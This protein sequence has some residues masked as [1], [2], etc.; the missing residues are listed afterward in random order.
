ML[1]VAQ[2]AQRKQILRNF[3]TTETRRH[4]EITDLSCEGRI[5]PR[6]GR[7]CRLVSNRFAE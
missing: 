7:L 1:D 6:L 2:E 3:F 5:D 4:G